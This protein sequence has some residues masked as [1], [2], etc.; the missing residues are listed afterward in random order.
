[1]DFATRSSMMAFRA[2]DV[3]R[4]TRTLTGSSGVLLLPL[5]SWQPQSQ[6]LESQL[7]PQVQ[8]ALSQPQSLLS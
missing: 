2:G 5:L 4:W 6:L 8:L 3:A 1:M 7:L